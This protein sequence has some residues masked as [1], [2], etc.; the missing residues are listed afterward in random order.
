LETLVQSKTKILFITARADFG[1]GQEHLFKLSK[2]LSEKFEIYYACPEDYPYYEKFLSIAGGDH[3]IKIPHREFS[4]SH[5]IG[6]AD[7]IKKNRIDFIHSH[8][9]GAGIYSRLLTIISGKKTIHTFH[10]L[11]VG[12]YNKFQSF[13]YLFLEK[14]LALFTSKIIAVSYGERDEIL[15]S[16]ICSTK[17]IQVIENGVEIPPQKIKPQLEE[18]EGL[19]ISTI[20]RFDFAKNSAMLVDIAEILKSKIGNRKFLIKVFGDGEQRRSVEEKVNR[21]LLPENFMFYGAVT[22]PQ[23]YLLDSHCYLST[24]RW[25]GLPLALLEAMAVGLPVVA[26]DVV[27]NRDVVKDSINGFL[28]DLN[29]PDEAAEGLLKLTRDTE[30]FAMLSQNARELIIKNFSVASM[31]KKTEN[32]YYSVIIK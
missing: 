24:S 21:K 19:V 16:R 30:L 23:E 9:K 5:L 22:N 26:T 31:V 25:E 3:L 14:T 10:G 27:G 4:Y 13:I 20:T 7:F 2:S 12:S 28:F 11:H 8:G 18:N 17:K 6:V 32:L 1:G 29:N 15:G